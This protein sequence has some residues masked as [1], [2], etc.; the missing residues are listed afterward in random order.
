MKRLLLALALL[1]PIALPAAADAV[2]PAVP[3]CQTA[4]GQT[5]STTLNTTVSP[6]SSALATYVSVDDGPWQMLSCLGRGAY[7]Y[8]HQLPIN[9]IWREHRHRFRHK[10]QADCAPAALPLLGQRDA[11]GFDPA[12]GFLAPPAGDSPDYGYVYRELN[13]V[14]EWLRFTQYQDEKGGWHDAVAWSTYTGDAQYFKR[15]SAE[16][17]ARMGTEGNGYGPTNVTNFSSWVLPPPDANFCVIRYTINSHWKAFFDKTVNSWMWASTFGAIYPSPDAI[18]RVDM[19]MNCSDAGAVVTLLKN[20]A[21][22]SVPGVNGRH[23]G[24]REWRGDIGICN[25][26]GYPSAC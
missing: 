19:K 22:T 9:W 24:V 8:V 10:S 4:G 16:N 17:L 26:P 25:T 3:E 5:C 2:D 20:E 6:G 11:V 12:L 14:K 23:Y 1:L 15:R 18:G 7:T 13:G 21:I